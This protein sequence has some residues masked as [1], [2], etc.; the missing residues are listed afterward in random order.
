MT[1]K[2]AFPALGAP[3]SP[4]WVHGG[5]LLEGLA[6][7]RFIDSGSLGSAKAVIGG[8]RLKNPL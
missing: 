4:A 5:P 3:M 6:L 1:T 2:P 7:P 8:F